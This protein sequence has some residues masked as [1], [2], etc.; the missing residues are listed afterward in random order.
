MLKNFDYEKTPIVEIV[1]EILVDATKRGASDIHF[2]PYE[3]FV[4]CRI[5]VDGELSDYTEIPSLVAKNLITRVKIISGMNITESR[6]PQDGAIKAT[7]SDINL[8]LRVSSLPTN[9]GEKIVIRILDYSMS[10]AGLE[11]LGLSEE[12]FKKVIKMISEPN[13][14]ILVTG[15]TGTGKST[16]VYS[17][18]QRL[19]K[20]NTNIISVEDPIEMDID[21]IN[22][23][24]TNSEI[25]LDFATVLRSILRQDPNIIMIGEIRDTE[26]A[27]IAVRASITG[28]LVLSTIHTNDS[29]NTIE[30]L[31]D[32]EVE[33]YL[34]ASA[35]TGIISQKLARKLCPHCKQ[36]R[37][38]NDYEKNIIKKVTGKEINEIYSAAGCD[39]CNNGYNGRIAIH[40]VLLID[41]DIKDAISSNVRKDKL[42]KLVYNE[43]LISLLQD[44]I[45][46]VLEGLTTLEELLKI[47]E[48]DDDN[49]IR[50]TGLQNAI[51]ANELTQQDNSEN[52]NEEVIEENKLFVEPKSLSP[53]TE[54]IQK[55]IVETPTPMPAPEE[56]PAQIVNDI[57]ED[58][59]EEVVK[60][61]TEE[62]KDDVMDFSKYQNSNSSRKDLF[63]NKKK[64]F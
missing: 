48:L 18:L 64:L 28:H 21:G 34:L 63:S 46:K 11:S 38:T 15:A 25:G 35:L 44:G 40:E 54:P 6:L 36:V 57:K 16:T 4:K 12:N 55:E 29:L 26:T 60:P 53:S 52:E 49:T 62:I 41:Q 7:L 8:D 42:R 50:P 19:N 2:D 24:Q 27:K 51:D 31:L 32:M 30:R 20:E 14:I 13:G 23:I 56:T 39:E 58:V 47:I 1:N 3:D 33:R 22:Q 10:L 43:N 61:T 5:R 9:K 45:S 59:Q 37:P 17:I